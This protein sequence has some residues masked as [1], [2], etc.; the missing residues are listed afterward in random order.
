MR[1]LSRASMNATFTGRAAHAEAGPQSGVNALH[2][3]SLTATGE[4]SLALTRSTS[5]R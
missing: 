1:T 4:T 2:A 3:A 5:D